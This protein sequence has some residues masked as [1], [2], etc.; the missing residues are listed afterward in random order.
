M[1]GLIELLNNKHVTDVK[2]WHMHACVRF[3]TITNKIHI[4][5]DSYFK[6][7]VK[8]NPEFDHSMYLYPDLDL[9]NSTS[10]ATGK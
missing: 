2:K 8:P 5:T 10:V 7:F 1:V 9:M 3:S 4:L 6:S